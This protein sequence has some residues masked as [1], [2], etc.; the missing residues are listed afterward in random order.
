MKEELSREEVQG[1]YDKEAVTHVNTGASSVE[2]GAPLAQKQGVEF[3]VIMN[4]NRSLTDFERRYSQTEREALAIVWACERL[5]TYLYG[6]KF[7][8]VTDHKPLE[9]NVLYSKKSNLAA[10]IERWVLLMQE[11]DYTFNYN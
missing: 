5:H 3:R 4:A 2:L 8:L 9:V 7:H 10:R 6:T 1:Y 11:F